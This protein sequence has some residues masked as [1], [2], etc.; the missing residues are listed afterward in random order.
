M[1]TFH[2]RYGET[3]LVPLAFSATGNRLYA[4]ALWLYDFRKRKRLPVILEC[5]HDLACR[6]NALKRIQRSG[7]FFAARH[8]EQII[9]LMTLKSY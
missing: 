4:P 2:D 1:R 5:T 7:Q 8:G 3:D 6:R 9:A